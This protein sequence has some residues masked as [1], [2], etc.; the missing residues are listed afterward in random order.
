MKVRVL[1]KGKP[2]ANTKVSFIP[3]GSELRGDLDASY[4][5]M[6][7]AKG[8]AQLTLREANSYLVAAHVSDPEAKGTGYKSIGYS[9]TLCILVPGVCPCCVKG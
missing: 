8:E 7:D 3:K 1:Y 9:A 2:A 5:K 6:T 4:E